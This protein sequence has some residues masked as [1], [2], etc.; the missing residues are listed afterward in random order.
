[1]QWLREHFRP[2]QPPPMDPEIEWLTKEADRMEDIFRRN[3]VAI[4]VDTGQVEDEDA[5]QHV[6]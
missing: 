6:D 5:A 1:M 3:G 2:P 4:A